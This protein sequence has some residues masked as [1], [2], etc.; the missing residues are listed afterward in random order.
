MAPVEGT[1]NVSALI[2]GEKANTYIQWKNH[3]STHDTSDLLNCGGNICFVFLNFLTILSLWAA[4]N[5]KHL[6]FTAYRDVD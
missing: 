2:R 5:I 1:L 3:C 4:G 6:H